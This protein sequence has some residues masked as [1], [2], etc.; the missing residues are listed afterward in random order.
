MMGFIL[1]FLHSIS[2]LFPPSLFF[3]LI[4][5]W[6]LV[7]GRDLELPDLGWATTCFYVVLGAEPVTY[8]MLSKHSTTEPHSQPSFLLAF[9][10]I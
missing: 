9:V 6:L 4:S 8:F 5:D 3:F 2:Y 10:F 7:V 1:L